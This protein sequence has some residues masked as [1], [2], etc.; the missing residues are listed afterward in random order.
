MNYEA[1]GV[2]IGKLVTRKQ[3]AYGDAVR[4]V[5]KILAILYPDGVRP[6]QYEDMLLITR[7]GDKL[8]RIATD[9]DALG[10]SPWADITGYGIL[11]VAM[12]GRS[13]PGSK[14][15]VPVQ[16]PEPARKAPAKP[17]A[18]P[19][20]G[21]FDY[22]FADALDA[23]IGSAW[24]FNAEDVVRL[25]KSHGR[26]RETAM[27]AL[28]ARLRSGR[29][30]RVADGGYLRAA[31]L[32]GAG[33]TTATT[34]TDGR[35]KSDGL[36]AD[37]VLTT[38]ATDDE[39]PL[40]GPELVA[41][42]R[43]AVSTESA[44][45]AAIAYCEERGSVPTP[46]TTGTA[47]DVMAE[48]R[49]TVQRHGQ[50]SRVHLVAFAKSLG[51]SHGVADNTLRE[52]VDAGLIV[53]VEPGIYAKPGP[54][55]PSRTAAPQRR[56]Q[57]EPKAAPKAPEPASAKL[58]VGGMRTDAPTPEMVAEWRRMLQAGRSHAHIASAYQRSVKA[59]HDA[60][61]AAERAEIEAAVQAGRVQRL[62]GPGPELVEAVRRREV[63]R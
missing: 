5:A 19:G 36:D 50:V 33:A 63:A 26:G 13:V 49:A 25:A 2:Q 35:G 43:D 31:A 52:A 56:P 60:V 1:I 57:A 51:L 37:A 61:A 10:E 46:A 55:L 32:A 53:R 4:R 11:G 39:D 34:A 27:K 24:V 6:D 3:A 15:P 42:M 17:K 7:I 14:E 22:A 28:R 21:R 44:N 47:V 20:K 12:S 58:S 23:M 48:L 41:A 8:C 9:R 59:V 16:S 18:R 62:P 29:L 45:R 40:S 38:T 54:I 30:V